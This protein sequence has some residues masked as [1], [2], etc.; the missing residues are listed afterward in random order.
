M[1]VEGWSIENNLDFTKFGH[2]PIFKEM[3]LKFQSLL[4][5][6][7]SQYH[8]VY[9]SETLYESK[10]SLFNLL[11][12][13]TFKGSF[14]KIHNIVNSYDFQ[15]EDKNSFFKTKIRMVPK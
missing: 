10:D 7:V 12:P 9:L 4:S 8:N 14:Y 5:P 11:V 13:M 15:L 1:T 2:E 3:E 6:T